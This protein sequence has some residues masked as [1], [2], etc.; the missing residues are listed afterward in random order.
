MRVQITGRHIEIS[1]SLRQH[2]ERA[3]SKLTKY[4]PQLSAADLVFREEGRSIEVEGILHLDGSD[5]MVAKGVGSG[6]REALDDLIGKLGRMLRR[7]RERR[8]NH[9]STSFSEVMSEE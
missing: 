9:K 2:A 1:A 5:L 7:H 6:A 3:V 4:D 8:T